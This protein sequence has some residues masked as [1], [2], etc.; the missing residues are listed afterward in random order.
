MI[1]G[2]CQP[3]H[4]LWCAHPLFQQLLGASGG[5]CAGGEQVRVWALTA[6]VSRTLLCFP[7]DIAAEADRPGPGRDGEVSA[8]Q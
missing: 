3:Q 7:H 6:S 5:L 4:H 2:S 8:R 1:P